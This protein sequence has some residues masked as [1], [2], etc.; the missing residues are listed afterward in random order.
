M[1]HKEADEE[2]AK[3]V[4]HIATRTTQI[5]TLWREIEADLAAAEKASAQS[6]AAN[7]TI[8]A[9]GH[10]ALK[11]SDDVPTLASVRAAL[12]ASLRGTI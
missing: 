1:R 6:R 10:E 12:P 3:L 9:F 8:E 5:A 7:E 11:F 4:A 2:R